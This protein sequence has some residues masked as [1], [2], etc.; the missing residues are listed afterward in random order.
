MSDQVDRVTAAPLRGGGAAPLLRR[1]DAVALAAVGGVV[2]VQ[3]PLVLQRVGVG[4]A[5]AQD[6]AVVPGEEGGKRGERRGEGEG[7]SADQPV[8]GQ[9]VGF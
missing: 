8:S 1:R 5:V 7:G 2:R 6:L 4:P 3:L 9:S